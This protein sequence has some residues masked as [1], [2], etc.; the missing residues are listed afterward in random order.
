M[1][2]QVVRHFR[3]IDKL[4]AGGMG[5]VYRA[6]DTR[7]NRLVAL[8]FLTG[9]AT[10][11]VA[12]RDRLIAEAKAAAAL[13][14]PNIGVIYG[15]EEEEERP[16]IV[17]AL[18]RGQNLREYMNDRRLA[19]LEAA[20]I[21][22]QVALG[23]SNAHARGITHR[24]IK[25]ENLFLTAE[26]QVKILDFGLAKQDGTV[27]LTS[28][29]VV[30]GTLEYMSPEQVRGAPLDG[31]SDIWALG[32]VLYEMLAGVSP[33]APISGVAGGIAAGILRIIRDEPE[34]LNSLRP[35]VPP[36]L[37]GVIERALRKAPD[38]RYASALELLSDLEMLLG[39]KP[40]ATEITSRAFASE[41]ETSRGSASPA[42]QPAP[43]LAPHLAPYLAA[44][45]TPQPAAL[46]VSVVESKRRYRLPTPAAS[47]VGR[48][49]EL[50]LITL[51]L[52]DP[53]CRVLTLFG[54]GGT[55]KTRLS[56]EAAREQEELGH[57]PD[58]VWF[59]ALDAVEDPSL[60]PLRIAQTLGLELQGKEDVAALVTGYLTQ[61]RALLVLDNFEHLM[62]SAELVSQFVEE[63]PD[64]KILVTSRERLA[65]PEEWVLPLRGLAAPT[66]V[67]ASPEEAGRYESVQLFVQRA[68]RANLRFALD[69]EDLRHVTEVCR[70]V[71]GSPL[72]LE[73]AAAWV[74]SIGCQEIAAE[75]R[76]NLDFLTGSGRGGSERHRSLR[77]TF[78]YSWLLLTSSEQR[79]LAALSVFRGGFGKDAAAGV[80]GAPLPLLSSLLDKSLLEVR[81]SKRYDFHPLLHQY[82]REKLADDPGLESET[83]EAHG[84]FFHKLLERQ[85]EQ[86]RGPEQL[87]SQHVIEAEL[88]NIRLAWN[89]AVAGRRTAELLSSS[90]TLDVF[91]DNCGRSREAAEMFRQAA[92]ALDP[93][94]SD[95]QQALCELLTSAS[96]ASF[97]LGRYEEARRLALESLVLL[98]EMPYSKSILTALN[99]LGAISLHTGEYDDARKYWLELRGLVDEH[100][101]TRE[102]AVVLG[103]LGTLEYA[104]GNY[105]QDK[106]YQQEALELNRRN[107]HVEGTVSALSNLA[108]VL[109]TTEDHSAARPLVEEAIE[110]ARR[111]KLTINLPRLLGLLGDILFAL[112]GFAA[113][114]EQYLAVL[115]LAIEHGDR[116]LEA[117]MYDN[118]GQLA[119]AQEEFPTAEAYFLRSL[120][121]RHEL[122][123]LPSV[124]KTLAG[125]A[126]L[127]VRRGRNAQA[128]ELLRA[129]LDHPTT[130]APIREQCRQLLADGQWEATQ[131]VAGEE[132]PQFDE[133]LTRVL[134]RPQPQLSAAATPI[135]DP[136]AETSSSEH[137]V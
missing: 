93:D 120:A 48:R 64:L 135:I 38:E 47:L 2:G 82:A 28:P 77:A 26:N 101:G 118:L 123:L 95:Q 54:P 7:L 49:D 50:E 41:A 130:D 91:F 131:E 79:A 98:R 6:E 122:C 18:Y 22:R 114:G 124:L 136:A 60:I 33:F 12:A 31:R 108:H 21:A 51:H 88:E 134:G 105:E 85:Y 58:G 5:V 111:H 127:E 104:L 121:L 29:G 106:A 57:F 46:P 3:I 89:W 99:S 110:L 86:L 102:A 73:L 76:R 35:D 126:K 59:I 129:V 92:S 62:D 34:P 116:A 137:L 133:L 117:T 90:P 61:R 81:T 65:T 56:L 125:L 75:I 15:I 10:R 30:V 19:P 16:F 83:V 69:S 107:N 42:A 71:E 94:D 1:D 87:T 43:N 84:A 132:L 80:A 9:E 67:P 112:G 113:A 17:M 100:G 68:K 37:Q 97:R 40:A 72:G 109:V 66:E 24:D 32:V 23:L 63:C 55:G 11:A 115:D 45:P 44:Q 20:G 128:A 14:H 52:S 70:L 27:G 4:G 103:N 13:D 53:H 8:K 36:A 96:F 74:K 78:E 39:S 119:T 25:P